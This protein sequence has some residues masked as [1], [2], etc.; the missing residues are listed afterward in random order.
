MSQFGCAQASAGVAAAVRSYRRAMHE[1]AAENTLDLWYERLEV[2]EISD[3]VR[4][5]YGYHVIQRTE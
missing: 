2:D 1:F 4:S 5:E 3:P